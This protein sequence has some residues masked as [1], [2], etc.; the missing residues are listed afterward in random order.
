VRDYGFE[1]RYSVLL[2]E[3]GRIPRREALPAAVVLDQ[4]ETLG[5]TSQPGSI[6]VQLPD[7]PDVVKP[8]RYYHTRHTTADG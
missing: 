3:L 2:S 5:E 7:K 8:R 1:V 6:D 4:H